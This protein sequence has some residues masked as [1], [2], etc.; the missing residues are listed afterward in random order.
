MKNIAQAALTVILSTALSL[1]GFAGTKEVK[2]AALTAERVSF[3]ETVSKIAEADEQ[4]DTIDVDYIVDENGKLYVTYISPVSEPLKLD[5]LRQVESMVP[6][7]NLVPGKVYSI[8]VPVSS[9][10]ML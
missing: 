9:P 2:F 8:Q 1:S 7:M 5:I 6:V 4:A 10:V 3:S